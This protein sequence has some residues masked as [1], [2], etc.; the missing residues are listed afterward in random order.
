M[1]RFATGIAIVATIYVHSP[2]RPQEGM[3]G[4]VSRWSQQMRDQVS[5]SIARSSLARD[6]AA[7]AAREA[8]GDL[9]GGRRTATP[10]AKPHAP[11]G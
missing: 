7:E 8:L 4:D 6:L 9:A 5:A 3:S 1:L 2:V 10:E 11:A